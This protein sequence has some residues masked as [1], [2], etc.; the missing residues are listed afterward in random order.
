MPEAYEKK[1]DEYKRRGMSDKDAKRQ[2]A[3][4][5]NRTHKNKM[6]GKH[7]KKGKKQ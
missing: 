1:R 6:G 2:A 4:W 7:K 5:Y 3:I